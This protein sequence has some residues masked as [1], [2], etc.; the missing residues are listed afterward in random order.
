MV[1][2]AGLSPAVRW[3]ACWVKSGGQVVRVPASVNDKPVGS[4]APIRIKH[5]RSLFFFMDLYF[6]TEKI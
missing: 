5:F 3:F 4:V 1:T 6:V 2:H